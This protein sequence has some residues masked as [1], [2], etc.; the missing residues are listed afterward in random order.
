VVNAIQ[1]LV[2]RLWRVC[3]LSSLSDVISS[4]KTVAVN[5]IGP[6]S[7]SEGNTFSV[8]VRISVSHLQRTRKVGVAVA[9]VLAAFLAEFLSACKTALAPVFHQSLG[10]SFLNFIWVCT[11]T[12]VTF[13]T[14]LGYFVV[15]LCGASGECQCNQAKRGEQ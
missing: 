11:F 10:T 1:F 6:P 14:V 7:S 2:K 8:L 3:F 12:F 5:V 4:I 15:A 13:R 9:V